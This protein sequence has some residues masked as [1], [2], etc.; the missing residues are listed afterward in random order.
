MEIKF[1]LDFENL[2]ELQRSK[3]FTY[4]SR[5]IESGHCISWEVINLDD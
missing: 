2:S 5:I 3:L 4:F 1:C